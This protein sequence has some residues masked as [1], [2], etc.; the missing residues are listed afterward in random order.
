MNDVADV[1]TVAEQGKTLIDTHA[2]PFDKAPM[3]SVEAVDVL[4]GTRRAL[5][6]K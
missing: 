6:R 5:A 1:M 2:R 4:R 3:A